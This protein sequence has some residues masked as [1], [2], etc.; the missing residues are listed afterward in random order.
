LSG[1]NSTQVEGRLAALIA[2][3][4]EFAPATEHQRITSYKPYL[5]AMQAGKF[6]G[7]SDGM[8]LTG[9]PLPLAHTN[10]FP[11]KAVPRTQ[12]GGG[13]EID[14]DPRVQIRRLRVFDRNSEKLVQ[15]NHPDIGWLVYD[16][17]GDGQPDSG[18]MTLEYTDV[19]EVWAPTILKMKPTLRFKGNDINDRVFNWLQLLNQ[20]Y[21]LPGVAN[22]DAHHCFHDSGVIRNWVKSPTDDPAQ[23]KELDVVR[24]SRKGEVI[25]SSGPFL[26]V[27]LNGAGPGDDLKLSG[28]GK[29]KVKVQC[30]NWFDIDRVQV[31]I[32]GQPDPALNFT[33]ATHPDMFTDG[34][35]KFDQTI[36]VKLATDAHVIVVAAGENS[37]TGPVMGEGEMPLAISNPIYVDNDGDG[38]KANF[39]TL[40][41]P[42]PVKRSPKE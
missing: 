31:L 2:E 14:K 24:A 38:F 37:S 4:I 7:T 1:D 6:M 23:I 25:M 30:P 41:A 17:D 11:L 8:E 9:T 21:R 18:Y 29:L 22:T 15:Q 19:I 34:V 5:Q 42:L 3:G 39:N 40:G 32:N 10:S 16:R 12:F 20:G 36:T 35:I 13:P 33:R 26:E 28:D 27:S